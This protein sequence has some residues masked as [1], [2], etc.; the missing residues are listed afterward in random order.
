MRTFYCPPLLGYRA[1]GRIN[2]G[3][4]YET[5]SEQVGDNGIL[6]RRDDLE[7]VTHFGEERV[8]EATRYGRGPGGRGGEEGKLV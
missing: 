6:A 3:T 2:N 8:A 5:K 1:Y 7:A 4:V